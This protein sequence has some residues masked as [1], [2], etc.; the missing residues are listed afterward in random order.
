MH[1]TVRR[2]LGMAVSFAAA[3]TFAAAFAPAASAHHH[4]CAGSL[5]GDFASCVIQLHDHACLGVDGQFHHLSEGF[6]SLPWPHTDC[7]TAPVQ[8]P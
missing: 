7:A 1:R 4:P 3:A 8:V 2:A 6:P 5:G